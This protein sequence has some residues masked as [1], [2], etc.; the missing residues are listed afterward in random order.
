MRKSQE[1]T[2][3]EHIGADCS[4]SKWRDI[5][6]ALDGEFGEEIGSRLFKDWSCG[7][8]R[9]YKKAEKQAERIVSDAH[10]WD[11]VSSIRNGAVGNL[12]EKTQTS[13]V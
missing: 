8:S 4:Y 6:F 10:K 9:R 7:G 11:P 1:G 12:T 2:V 13:T 5:G 3:L